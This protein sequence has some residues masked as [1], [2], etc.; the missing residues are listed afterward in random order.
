MDN[1]L[2]K[3]F[4]LNQAIIEAHVPQFDCLLDGNIGLCYYYSFLY[5]YTG[6]DKY[7]N[8]AVELIEGVFDRINNDESKL[9]GTSYANGIAGFAYAT[10]AINEILDLQIDLQ[11]EFSSIDDYLMEG[12]VSDIKHDKLDCLHSAF[13]IAHYFISRENKIADE[14]IKAICDKARNTS[15][16]LWFENILE[17]EIKDRNVANLSTSHGLTGMLLILFN[18]LK[19][20]QHKSIV[21]ET[22][23]NGIKFIM[24]NSTL[25]ENSYEKGTFYSKVN[26]NNN[27]TEMYPRLAWCYGDL[28][29]TILLYKC[30]E[31]FNDIN[32]KIIADKAGLN[33]IDKRS[34][35]LSWVEDP[36]FCHGSSGVSMMYK[37]MHKYSNLPEYK[38]SQEFWMD[39]TLAYF[40]N[41]GTDH[42]IYKKQHSVIDGLLGVN[43]SLVSALNDNSDDWLRMFFL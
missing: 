42:D 37:Q 3:Q 32:Y 39:Q 21:E 30:H 12:F 25:N 29:V 4:D 16:G 35:E 26:F 34:Q 22:I 13:G 11:D 33:T 7:R 36:F 28:G 23:K 19:Y 27:T 9:F 17:N 5:K 40:K 15:E 20:T 24:S 10:S 41:K 38:E 31:Y 2:L 14:V 1:I 18:S 8:A 6:L 43:L